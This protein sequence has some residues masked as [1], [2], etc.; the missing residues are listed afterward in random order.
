MA[1]ASFEARLE[2]MFGEAPAMRDADLFALRVLDRVDRGWTARRFLIGAMGLAGGVI[3]A[4]QLVGS[5]WG[6]QVQAL[7]AESNA[8][9]TRGLAQA[10]PPDLLPAGVTLNSQVVWTTLLL[11]VAAAGGGRAPPPPGG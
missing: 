9:L 7:G 10:I 6:G 3:G 4:V 1:E 8:Y 11:A 5:G 2:R